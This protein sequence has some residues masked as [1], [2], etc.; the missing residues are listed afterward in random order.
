MFDLLFFSGCICLAN[1]V[2]RNRRLIFFL[3]FNNVLELDMLYKRCSTVLDNSPPQWTCIVYRKPLTGGE[4]CQKRIILLFLWQ[5]TEKRV[6]LATM[7]DLD[8]K[9]QVQWRAKQGP[10]SSLTSYKVTKKMARCQ[11]NNCIL[12]FECLFARAFCKGSSAST[13]K[14]VASS[15][16][17][18]LSSFA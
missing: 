10:L 4:L 3:S 14:A 1:W 18:K 11:I 7:A 12:P 2:A 5:K 6:F 13:S 9:S 16:L 15:Y 17:R 8:H